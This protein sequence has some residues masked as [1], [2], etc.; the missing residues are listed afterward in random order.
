MPSLLDD[1]ELRRGGYPRNDKGS[2]RFIFLA[3]AFV[4]ALGIGAALLARDAPA[5][6][7]R[8]PRET[9]EVDNGQL[10]TTPL[11]LTTDPSLATGGVTTPIIDM[12][13]LDDGKP[14]ARPR[15]K[16]R[17]APAAPPPAAPAPAA[18]STGKNADLAGP[19]KVWK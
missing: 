11:G 12:G 19:I 10:D 18:P 9:S 5:S 6:T 15:P 13:D 17:R 14:H 2:W 3:A 7:R 8:T 4:G 1:G 16:V